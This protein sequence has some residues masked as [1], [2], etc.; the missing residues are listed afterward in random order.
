MAEVDIAAHGAFDGASHI[1]AEHDAVKLLIVAAGEGGGDPQ[2]HAEGDVGAVDGQATAG[3]ELHAVGACRFFLG[4]R[5]EN[6]AG[7]EV[8]DFVL[9][10]GVAFEPAGDVVGADGGLEFAHLFQGAADGHVGVAVFGG[11]ADV[12]ELAVFQLQ[13]AAALDV[14]E[15]GGHGVFHPRDRFV[16]GV[17]VG[18]DVGFDVATG[19]VGGAGAIGEEFTCGVVG[20]GDEV[21]GFGD[22]RGLIGAAA[23]EAGFQHRFVIAGEFGGLGLGGLHFFLCGAGGED[24]GE[25][26]GRLLECLV[27]NALPLA[28]GA[29][30]LLVAVAD[31][32]IGGLFGELAAGGFKCAVEGDIVGAEGGHVPI[33]VGRRRCAGGQPQGGEGDEDEG[34][35]FQ[36]CCWAHVARFC[37]GCAKC[38]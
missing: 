16:D 26:I 22:K 12:Q 10:G 7:V 20:A 31:D 34:E 33:G 13:R 25:V 35:G 28:V 17:G 5:K 19:G 32:F 4:H 3:G 2:R 38:D 1:V 21:G 9:S 29:E 36:H 30:G 8:E 18:A 14:E 24:A 27:A 37:K 6:I 23:G 11:K 15:E